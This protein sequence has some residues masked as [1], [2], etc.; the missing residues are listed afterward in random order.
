MCIRDSFYRQPV[1]K[2]I[3]P[4]SGLAQG[5]TVISLTGAW[6]QQVPE[7][8]VYPFCKIG[9]TIIRA[10]FVQTTRIMCV[11]P[12]SSDISAPLPILVSLN[13]V[14]FKATGFTFSYYEKPIIVDVQPRS[15]SVEGGTE[16]WLKGSKFSNIT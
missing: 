3:E 12:P 8:G 14:D 5:G 10:K 11:A 9:N 7:Y 15:G 6:F 13:G 16:I 2:K 1:V 4:S